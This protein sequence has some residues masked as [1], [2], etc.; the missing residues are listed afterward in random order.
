MRATVRRRRAGRKPQTAAR[1]ERAAGAREGGHLHAHPHVLGPNLLLDP[2]DVFSDFQ[3][4]LTAQRAAEASSGRH[5][6]RDDSGAWRPMQRNRVE[7]GQ[8]RRVR[9][10]PESDVWGSKTDEGLHMGQLNT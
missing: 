6:A 10:R 9:R 7:N 3:R 5:R 4:Q 2:Q 8:D 1:D